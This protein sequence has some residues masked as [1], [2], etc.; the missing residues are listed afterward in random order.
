MKDISDRLRHSTVQITSDIYT[1]MTVKRKRKVAEIYE[2]A[3]YVQKKIPRQHR[4]T[5]Q[6]DQ[7]KLLV[8]VPG[9]G[10]EPTRAAKPPGF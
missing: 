9:V 8:L 4:G 1:D 7:L 10:L 5:K 3:V 2:K 6:C